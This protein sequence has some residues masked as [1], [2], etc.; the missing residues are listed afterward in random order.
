MFDDFSAIFQYSLS[1]NEIIGNISVALLCSVFISY[2]YK[3]TYNLFNLGRHI[4]PARYYRDFK[5]SAFAS[6]NQVVGL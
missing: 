2:F 3:K 5:Q 1:T 4:I 6:W